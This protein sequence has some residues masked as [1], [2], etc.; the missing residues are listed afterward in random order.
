[1]LRCPTCKI[2]NVRVLRTKTVDDGDRVLRRIECDN[3]HRFTSQETV[4]DEY[5]PKPEPAPA[6]KTPCPSL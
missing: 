2:T 3:G 5:E 4:V 6:V 1:M